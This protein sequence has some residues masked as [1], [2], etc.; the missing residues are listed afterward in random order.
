VKLPI[1]S[2]KHRI[3]EASKVI[4]ATF[5]LFLKKIQEEDAFG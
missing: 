2:S 4:D 5:A 3:I 1:K